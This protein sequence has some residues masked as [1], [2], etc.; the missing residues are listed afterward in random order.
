[1]V[2]GRLSVD[3]KSGGPRVW[4]AQD[5]TVRSAFEVTA[6]LVKFLSPHEAE[7]AAAGATVDDGELLASD[8]D[9]SGAGDI[10]L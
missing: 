1:M 3:A 4:T 8:P 2:E 7:P 10:P 6:S 9:N 5:G